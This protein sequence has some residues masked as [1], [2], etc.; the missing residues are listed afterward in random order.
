MQHSLSVFY[1]YWP[2]GMEAHFF[3]WCA[4]ISSSVTIFSGSRWSSWCRNELY[5]AWYLT[6]AFYW[7][8]NITASWCMFYMLQSLLSSNIFREI[9]NGVIIAFVPHLERIQF[10]TTHLNRTYLLHSRSDLQSTLSILEE[11]ESEN[12]HAIVRFTVIHW[13]EQ[14]IRYW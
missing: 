13:V 9:Q 5:L 4:A 12:N 7:F 10:R 11:S 3:L 2:T 6:C 8:S 1:R 14:F